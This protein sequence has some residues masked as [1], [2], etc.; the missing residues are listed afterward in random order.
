M[1]ACISSGERRFVESSIEEDTRYDGRSLL[2]LRHL[3]VENG[4]IEF[5]NGSALIERVFCDSKVIVGVKVE[6]VNIQSIESEKSLVNVSVD[7]S[8]LEAKST[9]QRRLRDYA[10]ELAEQIEAQL[11]AGLDGNEHCLVIVPSKYSWCISVDV[12]VLGSD[13]NLSDLVSLA[14]YSALT[15]ARRPSVEKIAT[16]DGEDFQIDPDPANTVGM[17]VIFLESI[18]IRISLFDIGGHMVADVSESEEQCARC[19][20]SVLVN[21]KGQLCST[22]ILKNGRLGLTQVGNHLSTATQVGLSMFKL[23]DREISYT[24]RPVSQ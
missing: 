9:G 10:D 14:V 18:P 15:E 20:L 12:V 19:A 6:V 1:S 5:C 21:R 13:G 4:V 22:E 24:P 2:D 16:E 7:C 8:S 11:E 17:P 23:L 3:T